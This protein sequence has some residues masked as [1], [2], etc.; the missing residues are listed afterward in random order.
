MYERDD[1]YQP[2]TVQFQGLHGLQDF[3]GFQDLTGL[4]DFTGFQG[5]PG[6]QAA[7]HQGPQGFPGMQGLAAADPGAAWVAAPGS[8][9]HRGAQGAG[10]TD[11]L[12]GA[13]QLVGGAWDIDAEFEQLFR[14]PAAEDIP[15]PP[16]H[17]PAVPRPA[18]APHRRRRPRRLRRLIKLLRMPWVSVISFCIAL[19][20]GIIAC[21]VSL[22]GAMVSYDPLRLLAYPTAHGLASSWPL[23]VY[24][25]WLAGCLSVLRA[26]AHQRQ[27]KG[28]WAVV[29][30]FS[31]VAVALCVAHAPRTPTAMA[32]AGLPPV[33]ALA[34]FHLLYRQVTLVHPRHARL[35]RQR[36]K[37]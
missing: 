2:H 5:F 22:L 27:V 17:P 15:A 24:G 28:A 34:C 1:P 37:H 33:A 20:T 13:T 21:V 18:P 32:T 6:Y 26:A 36:R 10:A 3:S 7:G 8:G 30:G 4:Q 9:R 12:A 11:S 31:A 25:P 23:L 16:D 14:R 19:A 29:T 35:P